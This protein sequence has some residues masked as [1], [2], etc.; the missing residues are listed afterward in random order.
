MKHRVKPYKLKI[1]IERIIKSA[2]D[3]IISTNLYTIGALNL[4]MFSKE[5]SVL[6]SLYISSL[7]LYAVVVSLTLVCTNICVCVQCGKI[8]RISVLVLNC[9][10]VW[11]SLVSRERELIYMRKSRLYHGYS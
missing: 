11:Y 3:V 5:L 9:I 1:T 8:R 10:K 7:S 4:K 6:V 2:K